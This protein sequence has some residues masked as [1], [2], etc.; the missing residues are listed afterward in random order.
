MIISAIR[1]FTSKYAVDLHYSASSFLL[2]SPM[3]QHHPSAE[4]V[5][6]LSSGTRPEYQAPQVKD[7]GK[8]QAVTLVISLPGGPGNN[9]FNT[10]DSFFKKVEW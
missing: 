9:A 7:L 5:R 4:S 2:R 3:T 6:S 8:W 10:P 1:S